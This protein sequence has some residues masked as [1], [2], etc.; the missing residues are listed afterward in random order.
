MRLENRVAI[1]TG[2][3]RG[4]GRAIAMALAKEGAR[5]VINDIALEDCRKVVREIKDLGGE[6]L[7]VESD[8]T[9]RD[10]VE[11]MI[12][13][14]VDEFGK[15]DILVNNAMAIN[16]KPFLRL[17]D[18]DWDTCMNVNLKGYFLCT[19]AAAKQMTRNKWGRI[20]NIASISSGGMGVS[21]PLM[22]H[23][24]IAKGGVVAMTKAVA[25]ELALYDINV[26]AICPGSIDSG[27]LPDTM[28]DRMLA[29]IPKG[30]FGRP[31]EVGQL[32]VFLA[33]EESS[34]ITG[35]S[36]VIDGGWLSA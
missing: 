29:R 23:Y 13:K 24:T 4:I 35:A 12:K 14:T 16:F 7:A 36:I 1:V 32:A 22:S 20:I 33:S 9:S 10:D 18:E 34:Y 27:S 30:R 5:V 31:E 28:N 25:A 11:I 2:A 15:L 21:F 3:R 8:I 6:A 17:T 26:N 19:R